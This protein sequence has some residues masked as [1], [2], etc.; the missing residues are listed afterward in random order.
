MFKSKK[1]RR[2]GANGNSRRSYLRR[3]ATEA[4][5]DRRLLAG[6]VAAFQNQLLHSDV[7]ADGVVNVQD[8]TVVVGSLRNGGTR[9][10]V[11]GAEGEPG[12]TP[13]FIDVNGD[14]LLSVADAT[15]LVQTI[16]GEAAPGDLVVT[17]QTRVNGA[18]ANTVGVGQNFTLEVIVQDNRG[19]VAPADRGLL[20]GDFDVTFSTAFADFVS[21]AFASPYQILAPAAPNEAAGFVDRVNGFDAAILFTPP[22]APQIPVGP[23]PVTF[24]TITFTATAVGT[25]NLTAGLNLLGGFI[26]EASQFALPG[27]PFIDPADILFNPVTINVVNLSPNP[28][29]AGDDPNYATNE[30]TPLVV[31]A[32]GNTDGSGNPLMHNP[33]FGVLNNDSDADAG[34][35]LVAQLVG[36]GTTSAGGTVQLNSDGTFTYTPL[37]NFNGVDTFQ[38]F[39]SDGANQDG[40]ATV[41][42]S[43]APVPDNPVAVDDDYDTPINTPVVAADADGASTPG[44]PSDDGVLA[45]D[46]DDDAGDTPPQFLR[47]TQVNGVA[48]AN[49]IALSN[50]MLTMNADGTFTYTPNDPMFVGIE[51][52]TYTAESFTGVATPTG[53][54]GAT[55]NVEIRVGLE[56]H[57]IAGF[58]YVDKNNN[59]SRDTGELGIGGVRIDLTGVDFDGNPVAPPPVFTN[60]DGS[61]RFENLLAG[62]YIVREI[63]PTILLDGIDTIGSPAAVHV[64]P[65]VNDQF[66]IELPG[67]TDALDFNFGELGRRPEFYSLSEFL[68]S[69]GTGSLA[70][71]GPG[72]SFQFVQLNPLEWPTIVSLTV[73]LNGNGTA[74]LN[75]VDSGMNALQ[76]TIPTAGN[77]NFQILV[78]NTGGIIVR[79]GPQA[80]F[81]P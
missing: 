3:L 76:T 16:R 34:T 31:A 59:G 6:D 54:P 67:N 47:V 41:T 38:Y 60:A 71:F 48:I 12:G 56:P 53:E 39:A 22:A 68:A 46:S 35:T 45:N 81:F 17:L 79:L 24:S 69:S 32:A 42:I 43:V 62:T 75:A 57:T 8:L 37:T 61:Y 5:E 9:S 44:D 26:N 2:D 25:V 20:F 70:G 77:P 30:G 14:N 63:H 64:G 10:L 49:P 15:A 80:A 23:G 27:A 33:D 58:V 18:L 1:Q 72:A 29:M 21:V 40:P 7:N 55:G 78:Q 36:N 52:F 66:I 4:L 19:G 73:T 51:T 65:L 13:M 50:G 28:P 11:G 74:T